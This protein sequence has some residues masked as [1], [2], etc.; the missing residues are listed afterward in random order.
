MR[1]G[2]MYILECSDGSFYTGST[3][4]LDTRIWQH[5]VGF[6]PEYT[7]SRLPVKLVYTEEY[8]RVDDAFIREKQVQGWRR[9]KKIALINGDFD[10]LPSLSKSKSDFR[11]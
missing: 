10:K 4:D 11:S 5:K 7:R 1:G 8:D 6:G 9:D 2:W 3:N